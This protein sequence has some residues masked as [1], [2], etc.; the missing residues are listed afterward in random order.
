MQEFTTNLF[1]AD[2]K[3][4][5]DAAISRPGIDHG[6]VHIDLEISSHGHDLIRD[7]GL[8]AFELKI[9]A[10]LLSIDLQGVSWKI[11]SAYADVWGQPGPGSTR[12]FPLVLSRLDDFPNHRLLI[13]ITPDLDCFH[14]HFGSR[15]VA[16][17]NRDIV[18]LA[19]VICL[20]L[21]S[22]LSSKCGIK[23]D[24]VAST[25]SR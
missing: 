14:G 17:D 4:V 24:R 7:H 22:F 12:G 20:L 23:Y 19:H 16:T 5:S 9:Q 21:L 2:N 25:A 10:K 13:S 3:W 11:R 15:A 1:L 6:G 18:R 8:Q